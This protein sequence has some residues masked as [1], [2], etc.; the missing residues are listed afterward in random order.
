MGNV[1]GCVRAE[2]E[3]Q[4]FDP[5]KSPL[6]PEK[7]S[8]GRKYFRRKP[9]QKVVG[10]TELVWQSREREGKKGVSQPARGH[11]AVSS[12]ELPWEDPAASPTREDAV[13]LGKTA[14]AEHSEQRPLPSAVDS[15]PHRVTDSSAQ[16]RYSE[17]QVSIPDKTIPEEDS[18]PYCPET[19]RHLDD[20]NT[21]H[22]T[23]LRRDDV[24]LSQTA[25]SSSP[26]PC[27]TE[28]SPQNSALVGNL[29]K[30]CSSVPEQDSDERGHPLG[31]HCLQLTKRRYHSL[32]AGVSSV[33]TDTLGD[34]GCQVSDTGVTDSSSSSHQTPM[35]QLL[36]N[37]ICMLAY[38]KVKGFSDVRTVTLYRMLPMFLSIALNSACILSLHNL[39]KHRLNRMLRLHVFH[40]WLLIFLL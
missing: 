30:S 8:P 34:D 31:A 4:Y 13:Q 5:A 6:S 14:A 27:V 26:I 39:G 10:D 16:G 40:S 3:E 9:G 12:G 11:P 1:C 25:A 28:K 37:A 32:S 2:K 20:V 17:V 18:P 35:L 21:K 7:Y 22:T 19:E 24:S 33:S 29:S 15:C 23:F 36:K 38:V